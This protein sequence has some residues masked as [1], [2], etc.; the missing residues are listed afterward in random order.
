MAKINY[1]N[2][3]SAS[4]ILALPVLFYFALNSNIL[5]FCILYLVA[6]STDAFDGYIARK[7]KLESKLGVI[8]DD[9]G[10]YLL[11]ISSLGLIYIW[12]PFVLTGYW[13][14]WLIMLF[15]GLSQNFII[16]L[17]HKKYYSL[18]LYSWKFIGVL[19]SANTLYYSVGKSLIPLFMLFG[20][21]SI[22]YL[23]TLVIII[24]FKKQIKSN[25]GSVFKLM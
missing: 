10:D 12:A 8:L 16:Y 3:L 1:A 13:Y 14:L 21:F 7:M 20:L 2:I 22:A 19:I 9:I 4:R 23:E 5:A 25:I 18:H 11:Y 24:F 17:I 6:A 15:Y